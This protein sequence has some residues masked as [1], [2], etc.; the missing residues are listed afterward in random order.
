MHYNCIRARSAK[1]EKVKVKQLHNYSLHRLEVYI[2]T[3][4]VLQQYCIS[5]TN[6]IYTKLCMLRYIR[7]LCREFV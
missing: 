4:A 1:N 5:D 7:G 2:D 6:N 3:F